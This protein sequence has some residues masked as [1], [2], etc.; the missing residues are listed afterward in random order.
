MAIF[1]IRSIFN[2]HGLL[3]FLR[4][5][6]CATPRRWTLSPPARPQRT[7]SP[8]EDGQQGRHFGSSSTW[9]KVNPASLGWQASLI[10][11]YICEP[12]NRQ[13]QHHLGTCEKGRLLATTPSTPAKVETLG[14]RAEQ[15]GLSLPGDSDA[16]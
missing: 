3:Q 11:F 14:E 9:S 5:R 1:P 6:L 16:R 4:T 13:H 10:N 2:L 12:Q 8:W 7:M 15:S